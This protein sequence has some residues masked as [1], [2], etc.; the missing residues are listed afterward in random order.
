MSDIRKITIDDVIHSSINT[1]GTNDYKSENAPHYK[2]DLFRGNLKKSKTKKHYTTATVATAPIPQ[3]AL[4]INITA[5]INSNIDPELVPDILEHKES[6]TSNT[7]ADGTFFTFSY[8]NPIIRVKELNG[9]DE[10]DNFSITAFKVYELPQHNDFTVYE[11]LNFPTKEVKIKDGIL[12]DVN[13][14]SIFEGE[15]EPQITPIGGYPVNHIGHFLK[16]T[17][18]MQIPQVEICATIGDLK[19]KNIFLDE[20]LDCPDE[21]EFEDFDIYAS[22]VKPEDLEDCD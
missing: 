7:Y 19:I 18:D 16:L 3:L 1:V 15:E 13:E 10:S 2:V 5:S 12:L 14:G 9:F 20:K 6:F 17:T 11:K 8:E 22:R 4:V 21:E